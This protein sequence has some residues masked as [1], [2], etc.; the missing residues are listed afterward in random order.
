[1]SSAGSHK[2]KD[3]IPAQSSK[4]QLGQILLGCF[5]PPIVAIVVTCYTPD[6]S[7]HTC[8][9]TSDSSTPYIRVRRWDSYTLQSSWGWHAKVKN[10]HQPH[11]SETQQKAT[12]PTILPGNKTELRAVFLNPEVKFKC[13]ALS[14]CHNKPPPEHTHTTRHHSYTFMNLKLEMMLHVSQKK[15]SSW[16]KDSGSTSGFSTVQQYN[17]TRLIMCNILAIYMCISNSSQFR[18]NVHSSQTSC[19]DR[20]T[21]LDASKKTR[22][23]IQLYSQKMQSEWRRQRDFK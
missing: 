17:W 6:N 7:S 20:E 13:V 14:T 11:M 12:V 18:P 15:Q 21:L 5:V 1:M 10:D 16:Q 23:E 19:S 22:Q 4:P 3:D 8:S 2:R 9:S